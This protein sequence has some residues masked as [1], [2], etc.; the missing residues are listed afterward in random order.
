M[1]VMFRV[2]IVLA[3]LTIPVAAQAQ[4][5]IGVI[6]LDEA[7]NGTSAGKSAFASLKSRFEPRE[8]ALAAQGEELKNMQT[9]LQKKSVALSKDAMKSKAAEFETKARKYMEDSNKLKQ[10]ID[11]ANQSTLRPLFV[12]LQSV[13]SSFAAKNGYSVIMESRSVPYFDPKSDVTAAVRAEFEKSK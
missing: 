11:Q 10:E 3:M 7:L 6:N 2:L 8:R 13:L 12:K 5:K 4:G 1:G 9:E